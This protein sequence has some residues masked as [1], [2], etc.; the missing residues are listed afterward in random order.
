MAPVVLHALKCCGQPLCQIGT[1]RCLSLPLR[2]RYSEL[3]ISSRTKIVDVASAP[4]EPGMGKAAGRKVCELRKSQ[5]E[6]DGLCGLQAANNRI[7]GA[8]CASG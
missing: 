4:Q 7:A 2:P 1:Q 5:H 8:S 3:Q 6:P